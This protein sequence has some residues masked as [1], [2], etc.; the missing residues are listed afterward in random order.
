MKV[1]AGGESEGRHML[2]LRTMN[3][4][5]CA[6]VRLCSTGTHDASISVRGGVHWSGRNQSSCSPNSNF[7]WLE[8]SYCICDCSH[9]MSC[10]LWLEV[11]SLF[12]PPAS[13][14]VVTGW[15]LMQNKQ[16]AFLCHTASC[17]FPTI[18]QWCIIS[19]KQH[20]S[21]ALKHITTTENGANNCVVSKLCWKSNKDGTLFW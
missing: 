8:W 11:S 1:A 7:Y 13:S 10:S 15:A 20:E 2:S 3:P 12:P 21:A 18:T 9:W 16:M 19:G 4:G 5:M 6:S 17:H 14:T